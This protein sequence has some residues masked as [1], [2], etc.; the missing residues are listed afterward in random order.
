[1]M[2]L[3]YLN[4]QKA[5]NKVPH[6]RLLLKLKAHG[7]GDGVINGNESIRVIVDSEIL[8]WKSF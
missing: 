8:N 5:F 7:I 3:V 4:F 1:M 6:Q 2:G